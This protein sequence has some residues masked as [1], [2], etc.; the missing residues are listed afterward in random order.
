MQRHTRLKTKKLVIYKKPVL[1]VTIAKPIKKKT[2]LGF[3]EIR[4]CGL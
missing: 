2:A 1:N 3:Q 4:V